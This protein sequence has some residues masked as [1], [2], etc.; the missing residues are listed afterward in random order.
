MYSKKRITQSFHDLLLD[1]ELSN[2]LEQSSFLEDSS[3]WSG[4][5]QRV[6]SLFFSELYESNDFLNK[7][8]D[9]HFTELKSNPAEHLGFTKKELKQ[10]N[11]KL[12]QSVVSL[13]AKVVGYG[14][15]RKFKS[16]LE[17][18]GGDTSIFFDL[19]Y[20]TQAVSFKDM[21]SLEAINLLVDKLSDALQEFR[22]AKHII[23]TTIQLTY[24]TARIDFKL[25]QIKS[26][27]KLITTNHLK[28]EWLFF[29]Q[30]YQVNE[31]RRSSLITYV[32]EHFE[33]L[34]LTIVENTAKSGVQYIGDSKEAINKLFKKSLIGGGVVA[35]FALFKI[36][37]S[38]FLL[39]D[40]EYALFSSL[41]YALC[42][43]LV[44]KLGGS[45]ATKQSALT[46]STIVKQIDPDN[47]LKINSEQ[48][49]VDLIRRTNISQ[50]ASFAG[51]LAV[52][53]PL[54]LILSLLLSA[55]F[56]FE[57]ASIA[58]SDLLIYKNNIVS[59]NIILYASV[60][61]IFLAIAGFFSGF[62]DNKIIVIRL[63]ERL[64][65]TYFIQKIF[66]I[67]AINYIT[68]YL[69]ENLGKY[70]GNILLGF[71][72][73]SIEYICSFTPLHLEIRH[74][75]FSS[76]NLG[77]AIL[78]TSYP[79]SGLLLSGLSICLIGLVN[80]IVSFSITF[81]ITLLSRRVSLRGISR[82]LSAVFSQFFKHPSR[83]FI[84]DK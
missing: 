48:E 61:G 19:Y 21:S 66:S 58:K 5:T 34:A 75:A 47:D 73:G 7:L 40:F 69:Y 1:S 79:F 24:V 37:F 80:F 16:K 46:A 26:I 4:I 33:L 10:I 13:C 62:I 78:S 68:D 72:L 29:I 57:I 63:K 17:K 42:F 84:L 71:L 83:F 11:K 32:K 23:G 2:L 77:Y 35:V 39:S 8:N 65:N 67:Q 12:F 6:S 56:G 27:L 15:D 59:S 30:Q 3:F 70:S 49:V 20:A 60:A 41:N 25:R 9:D 64:E 81:Y 82:L 36:L 43:I 18:V 51:N 54:S 76:A 31:K 44:S 22:E 14:T 45:I 55:L 74:I 38:G 53:F 50:F 28:S 52:A